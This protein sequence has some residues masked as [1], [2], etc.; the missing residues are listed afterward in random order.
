[1]LTPKQIDALIQVE[2]LLDYA[3]ANIRAGVFYLRANLIDIHYISTV[4]I[5]NLRDELR[6]LLANDTTERLASHNPTP[7]TTEQAA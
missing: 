5:G 6:T 7:K 1:M 3:Q 4:D 2:R